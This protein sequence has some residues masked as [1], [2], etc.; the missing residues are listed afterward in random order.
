M[1]FITII[2]IISHLGTKP[3]KGGR[4]PKDKSLSGIVR[5]ENKVVWLGFSRSEIVKAEMIKNIKATEDE[6]KT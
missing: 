1:S 6:I 3:V 2:W 5:A 4:P